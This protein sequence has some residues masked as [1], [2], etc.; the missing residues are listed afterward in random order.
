MKDYTHFLTKDK[1]IFTTRGNIH[2]KGFIRSAALYRNIK[3][4]SRKLE[5]LLF[6]KEV[7]EFGT[8]WVYKTNPSY[9]KNDKYGRYILVPEEDIVKSFD[10]FSKE[11]QERVKLALENSVWGTLF[12]NLTK[13]IPIED[14]GFIGSF[15]MGFSTKESDLD[16]V[17]RG[18]KNLEIIKNNFKE[19]LKTLKA[20]NV[21]KEDIIDIS[22]KKYYSIYNKNENDFRKMMERRWSTIVTKDY[23]LKIRFSYKESEIDE[24]IPKIKQREAIVEG[25]VIDDTG[26]DFMPRSF[27]LKSKNKEYLVQTYFWDFTYCVKK[28]D[29]I[30]VKAY[31]FD[32]KVL[33]LCEPEKHGIKFTS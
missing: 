32:N 9:V 7:D 1:I 2:P 8:K 14:I 31:L 4:G 10:P 25:Q 29:I 26:V 12:R 33:Y 18:K 5:N 20:I 3:E 22:L 13:L 30:K 28:G 6:D 24:I 19:L 23:M 11:V 16:I 17:V 15:L 21:P 27:K